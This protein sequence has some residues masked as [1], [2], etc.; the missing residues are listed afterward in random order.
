MPRVWW[1][2]RYKESGFSSVEAL[3]A[4]LLFGL[5]VIPLTGAFIYGRSA[6][7]G[8]GNHTRAAFLAN[9][10]IE[11]VRNI[12]D[13]AYTD[14]GDGTYGLVRSGGTW[15]LSGTSD[16]SGIYS[17]QVDVSTQ[18]SNRKQITSTVSWTLA[19][20][21]SQ[22]VMTTL[23]SNWRQSLTVPLSW[24]SPSWTG[25]VGVTGNGDGVKVATQG[26][27]A[28]LIRGNVSPNLIVLDIADRT[29]P[30][31]VGSLSLSGQPTDIAVQ[32][33]YA[34][35]SNT[36]NAG[37]IQTVSVVNP[38]APS[39]VST[40]N[41]AGN[42]NATSVKVSGSN[43][44]V[45]RSGDATSPG[46]VI[47]SLATPATPALAGSF[48]TSIVLLDVYING[49]YAFAA[50]GTNSAE[51]LVLN[52]SVP[53]LTQQVSILDL[54]G[55]T[56]ASSV[57]GSASTVYLGQGATL[58]SVD[59]SNPATPTVSGSLVSSG[60]INDLALNSNSP[61]YLFVGTSSSA[62]EFQVVDVSSPATPTLRATVDVAGGTALLGVAYSST[63]DIVVGASNADSWEGVVFGPN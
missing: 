8:A 2:T 10:G 46:F 50:A 33:D 51:L 53:S 39:L 1:T 34:Y 23:L 41:L 3:L 42:G 62:A 5:L 63:R 37:E 22:S 14:L 48:G 31:I 29:S 55:N 25:S 45:T 52:V 38:A 54:P 13:A 20:R 36:A 21:T 40:V 61:T 12:R 44:Y 30:V 28:Y 32:G 9:E 27:Y 16:T 59:V 7:A 17:R 60:T 35:V 18:G 57:V 49:S 58:H 6:N 26:D 56:D 43:L 19:G 47:M 15:T 24:D 11:A 4:V